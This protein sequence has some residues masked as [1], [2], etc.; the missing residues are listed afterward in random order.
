MSQPT[1]AAGE[2][3]GRDPADMAA[4]GPPNTM[5][6]GSS[7]ATEPVSGG[8]WARWKARTTGGAP[9]YPLV[10]LFGLNAVDELDRTAFGVLL[11]EIRDHFGL[12]TGGILTVVSLA[13]IAALI[14]ALPIGFYSD[15]GRR[16]PIAVGGAAAWG[17][18]SVFT[19]LA[20]T[21]WMLGIAR[22]GSG[23]G[24]A[25]ND[26]VH[27][28]LLADYYDVPVRPRVYG[29]HRYANATGQFVGAIGAGLLAFYLGWRAPFFVFAIVTAIF[30]ILALRLREPVRGRFERRAMGASAVVSDT[31]EEAPSWAESWRILW[32]VRSLR[33]IFVALPFV[34]IAIVGFVLL[35]GLFY[36]EIFG[37]DERARGFVIA[38]I[39]G[40]AHLM[41]LLL[42]IP[43]ATKL[44]AGGPGR[45]LQ[46]LA[47]VATVVS[48][49]WVLFALAPTLP[50]AIA[51][52]AVVSGGLFLLIPGIFAVLSLAI[53]AK[54]RSFGFAVGTLFI[55]PGL[56]LLPVVGGLADAYGIRTGLIV[57][58]PVFVVGGW[59]IASAGSFVAHDIERV[60]TTAAARSEVA[61]LRRQ[62]QVKLLL[63]RGIDVHYDGIQVL[64]G[65]DLEVD[66]GEIVA[67]L[68]TNGAGK[69]TLLRA[70][71]GLVQPSGGAVIFDGRDVT[72]APPN[73][74]AAR[75]ITQVPGGQGVFTNLSVA[76][77]LRLAGWLQRRDTAQVREAT[78]RVLEIFPQLRERL[79]EPAGNLS[80][81]QQQMLTLGM[82]F[83]GRPR[84]L[85]IDELS[86]GLAPVVVAQLLDMVRMLRDNG[87]TIIL[88]EQ[89]VN[90]A[91]TVAERAFFME[92]GEIRFEGATSELLSRPDLLRSVF[93]SGTLTGPVA[94][95]EG[96]LTGPVAET[97]SPTAASADAPAADLDL[98]ATRSLP[99]P[100]LGA[101]TSSLMDSE[102]VLEV[103][104]LTKR[105]GG[106]QALDRVS[107]DVRDDEIL[108]FIGPNGAGKTTL[109]DVI[110]GFTPAE[111]GTIRL[112]TDHG[113]HDLHNASIHQ[114]AW[115]GLGRSFQDGRLFPGLTVTETLAVA[116]E[117]HVEVRDPLA[118]S[119]HL[120]T[121][122]D[123]ERRL[124]QRVEELIELLGLGAY[125]DKF[126]RELST[127]TRRIV[128]LGCVLAQGPRVVL[129]DEPSSGIAQ[130]EAEAL[131]PVLARVRQEL[132]ASLL[133]IEHD[134]PLLLG[135]AD[136]MIALDLGRII[137]EGD[138]YEVVNH[139]EVITSY[140]GTD[141]AAI[142][143]SGELAPG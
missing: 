32:Q 133:I 102:T 63:A 136:R 4:D 116:L 97:Q 94:A 100:H 48:V 8:R 80:G 59:I 76:D 95:A 79:H 106:I 22:A 2:D 23:L 134:L 74:I 14:L 130:R 84:L 41:G 113:H 38:G 49:A 3:P 70:M 124:E 89:S 126:M 61:H 6:A 40:P 142:D 28:S 140:L 58:A 98:G 93:L 62:G 51:A 15:R 52:N 104:E 72:N 50:L 42:G 45:V 143:R 117:Q 139:P 64:F 77:N 43:L 137:A 27:N 31:E 115:Q 17:V 73:E 34:A 109:F 30:V 71:S 138:P 55:L 81:G 108:G 121:V 5:W 47:Y 123:S 110:S 20:A 7:G 46:F 19:G 69:S 56:L 96:P 118:A 16:V 25:V 75:G 9:L 53:P 65:V 60:W 120:P 54:V 103:R 33:R 66:E 99:D 44:L 122:G 37:L 13:L 101:A 125:R 78:A 18:C 128:D 111:R 107:F 135:L 1:D 26:P 83:I 87:T 35:G 24:R 39:E 141:A 129:L 91:L 86:L 12:G 90:L 85:M 119:L 88:V 112:R 29:V 68:G 10:V 92:K 11:P 36:E 57:A 67:L 127:G 21:L 105:F 82:A 131:G 132:G 114:R